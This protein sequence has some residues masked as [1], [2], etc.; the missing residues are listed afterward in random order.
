MNGCREGFRGDVERYGKGGIRD[1]KISA[2]GLMEVLF[3]S[4]KGLRG[5]VGDRLCLVLG[6]GYGYGE[7][8]C[9]DSWEFSWMGSGLG[10]VGYFQLP[11][12]SMIG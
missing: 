1:N 8:V 11:N 3:Q 5:L 2:L 9:G 4:W 7:G 10:R 6:Y 12:L